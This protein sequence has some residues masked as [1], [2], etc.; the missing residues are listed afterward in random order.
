[1]AN[2]INT[3]KLKLV[4]EDFKKIATQYQTEL[5]SI[6]GKL[7]NIGLETW[8]STSE[9]GSA[10]KFITKIEK[11]KEKFEKLTNQMR[12]YGDTLISL[13]NELKNITEK[14]M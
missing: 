10:K 7:K 8:T 14:E 4:G 3:E 6:Y 12:S 9:T 13:S 2:K 11:D 1:M 5:D